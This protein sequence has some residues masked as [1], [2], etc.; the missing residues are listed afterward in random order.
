MAIYGS[1]STADIAAYI[2][3]NIGYNDEAAQIQISEKDIVFIGLPEG[4]DST[5][6]KHLGQFEVEISYKGA[7]NTLKKKVFV[8]EPRNDD[9]E[10]S[11]QPKAEAPLEQSAR[12]EEVLQHR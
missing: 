1:V 3:K 11:D 12:T 10:K 8:V 9:P 6:V 4:E 5:R 7:D 2:K